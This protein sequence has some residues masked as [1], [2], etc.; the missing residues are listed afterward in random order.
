[1]RVEKRV[2]RRCGKLYDYKPPR[3]RRRKD[4][5][6]FLKKKYCPECREKRKVCQHCGKL[7]WVTEPN[8]PLNQKYCLSCIHKRHICVACGKEYFKSKKDDDYN[9]YNEAFCDNCIVKNNFDSNKLDF[10]LFNAVPDDTPKDIKLGFKLVL[11]MVGFIILLGV[12]T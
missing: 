3:H 5:F 8:N 7:Y 10:K 11:M 1:M 2:C 12:L 6:D 9:E 4:P